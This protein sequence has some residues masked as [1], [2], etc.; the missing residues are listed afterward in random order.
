MKK[1]TKHKMPSRARY[2]ESHPVIS[3]RLDRDTYDRLKGHLEESGCS[4][5]DFV[6]D[7]LGREDSMIE[8]RVKSWHQDK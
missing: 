6:K 3:G 4:F 2:D 8:K 5:A 1:K 7:T